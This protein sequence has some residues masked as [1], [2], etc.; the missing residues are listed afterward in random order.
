MAMA[1]GRVPRRRG[2]NLVDMC[3]L[4]ESG[5]FAREDFEWIAEWGFDFVRLP[6]TYQWWVEGGD[7][8]KV[9]E[10][11]LERVDRAV[12]F[13]RECG[14][15]V[16]LNFHRAPGFCTNPPAEPFDLW[17]DAAALEAFLFHWGLFAK[18]YKGIPSGRMSFNLV[19]EPTDEVARADHERVMR[20]AVAHIRGIDPE[21]LIIIDGLSWGKDPCPELADLGV[22]QS[23]RAYW[24]HSLSHYAVPWRKGGPEMPV[25]TWPGVVYQGEAWDRAKLEEHYRPWVDLARQGIG[26]HCGEGGCYSNTPHDVFL[27]W[28]RDV[29]EILTAAGIGWAL[30]E[31]R[32]SFGLLDSGR[33]DVAYEDWRGHKLDRRLLSLLQEF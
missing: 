17:K 23:C 3:S 2:F 28:Y 27:A 15:H 1:G 24:P 9:S 11:G 22:A 5:E 10:A 4:R 29:L 18:R 16:N 14:L 21:R 12:E 30:W 13:A 31:F 19:N 8:H 20:A 33:K 6:M 26:V 7:A 25:P 32:G